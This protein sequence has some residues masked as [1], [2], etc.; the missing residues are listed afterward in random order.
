METISWTDRV[1]NEEVLHRIKEEWNIILAIQGRRLNGLATSSANS[2]LKPLLK[3]IQK[4]REDDDRDVSSYWMTLRN[5]Q[6][7]G[8]LKRK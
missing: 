1:T 6:N 3:E 2:L 5:G 7:T 4:R 8:T